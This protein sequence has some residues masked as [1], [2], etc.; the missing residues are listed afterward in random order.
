MTDLYIN[1]WNRYRKIILKLKCIFVYVDRNY[2]AKERLE[3]NARGIH[4]TFSYAIISW[5]ENVLQPHFV[6]RSSWLI[7]KLLQRSRPE[8]NC[9]AADRTRTACVSKIRFYYSVLLSKF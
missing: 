8:R 9:N 5:H 2:V 7:D 6:N 1:E 3:Q 4:D